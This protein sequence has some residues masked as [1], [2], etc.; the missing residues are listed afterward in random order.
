MAS[1]ANSYVREAR[2]HFKNLRDAPPSDYTTKVTCTLSGREKLWISPPVEVIQSLSGKENVCMMCVCFLYVFKCSTTINTHLSIV[3]GKCTCCSINDIQ[4]GVITYSKATICC[5]EFS[6]GQDIRGGKYRTCG[7]VV[8][9]VVG[10]QSRYGLVTHFFSHVCVHN[11]GSYAFI[12]WFNS[13]DYPFEGTP[14]IVRIRDDA[15]PV[16][17]SPLEV[18]SIFDID[19]SRI[20]VE[21][22]DVESCYYMCRIEGLD[23]ITVVQT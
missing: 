20:I 6:A 4:T 8:T 13:T 2:T 17:D 5:V 15:E 3:S 21:R 9:C 14:L 19:P 16:C 23:T 7:S 1:V 10:G 11:P 22:S 12:R 18:L